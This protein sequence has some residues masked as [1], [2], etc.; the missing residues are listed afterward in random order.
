MKRIRPAR[1]A[2]LALAVALAL[3]LVLAAA[4]H[5]SGGL[6]VSVT[7]QVGC[8]FGITATWHP[9][10]GQT[11]IHF[12]L[13]DLITH[14]LDNRDEPVQP[15]D[16]TSTEVFVE[17]PSVAGSDVFEAFAQVRNRAGEELASGG[18]TAPF[19]AQCSF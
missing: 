1:C 5:A 13:E 2:S 10:H 3:T 14:H 15:G 8:E 7:S 4:A 17:P 12:A 19:A 18:P 6:R 11:S 16:S 9:K